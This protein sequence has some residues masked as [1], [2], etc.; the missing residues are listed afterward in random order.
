MSS[1]TPEQWTRMRAVY[2]KRN[3]NKGVETTEPETNQTD[4]AAKA[5]SDTAYAAAQ[6]AS[7]KLIDGQ[8]AAQ[9]E[10]NERRRKLGEAPRAMPDWV[11]PIALIA[12]F[13]FIL[14]YY[15]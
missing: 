15:K 6:L 10:E 12:L 1:Y 14:K 2:G 8:S 3:F 7:Q 5:A 11:V 9:L 4:A 13:G